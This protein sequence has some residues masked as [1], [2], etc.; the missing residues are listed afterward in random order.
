MF[1]VALA[2]GLWSLT[3]AVLLRSGRVR[4]GTAWGWS[5]AGNLWQGIGLLA[6]GIM[7]VFED[8]FAAGQVLGISGRVW[9]A[10]PWV[11]VL[12]GVALRLKARREA[13]DGR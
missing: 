6:V 8:R 10:L 3:A 4:P 12:I 7:L 1:V 11:L 2:L 9:L 13:W 5:W